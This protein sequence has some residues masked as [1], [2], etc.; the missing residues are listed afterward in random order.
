MKNINIPINE[1]LH[2]ALK[3]KALKEKVTLKEMITNILE[4]NKK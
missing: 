4:E 2:F 1:D 3:Q